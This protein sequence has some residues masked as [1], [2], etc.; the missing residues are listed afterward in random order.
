MVDGWLCFDKTKQ[1]FV[2]LHLA[3]PFVLTFLL[4]AGGILASLSLVGAFM[5][6]IFIAPV[7]IM[8]GL[9]AAT[10]FGGL[11]FAAAATGLTALT[12]FLMVR[13]W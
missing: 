13:V 4:L 12:W 5:L 7:S 2:L 1:S 3:G 8:F 9:A 10:T 6:A 11:A